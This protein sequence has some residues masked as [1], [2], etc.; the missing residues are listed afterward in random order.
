M[1]KLLLAMTAGA[2]FAGS[3][4]LQAHHSFAAEFDAEKTIVLE[5]I[6]T[7]VEWTNPHVWIYMNVKDPAT[8]EMK[9]WGIELGPPHLLQR[10]GWRRE[11]LA[12]GTKINADGFM[13][14][15]GSDRINARTVTIAG[16]G[17]APGETLDAGSSQLERNNTDN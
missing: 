10:R 13:A 5:G 3:A 12:L 2:L 1:K 17:G 8:N 11:S 9:N 6:V 4:N 14:R 15:N 7:K 16:T